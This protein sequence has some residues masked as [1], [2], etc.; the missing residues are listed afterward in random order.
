MRLAVL[1]RAVLRSEGTL[2]FLQSAECCCV[3]MTE[4]PYE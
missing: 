4:E 3:H 2:H 1:C